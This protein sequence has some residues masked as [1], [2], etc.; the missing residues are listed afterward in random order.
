MPV[1]RVVATT[2]VVNNYAELLAITSDEEKKQTKLIFDQGRIARRYC[3]IELFIDLLLHHFNSSKRSNRTLVASYHLPNYKAP[4]VLSLWEPVL[5]T[6]L[7]KLNRKINT[8]VIYHKVRKSKRINSGQSL[9]IFIDGTKLT[10][11][12]NIRSVRHQLEVC[13][14]F[15]DR[16]RKR[17]WALLKEDDITELL[18]K[19][20][21]DQSE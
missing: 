9:I 4:L 10:V 14:N 8:Y 21:K 5:L 18:E 1:V 2:A 16:L 20:N 15:K 13:E 19:A 11:D 12:A 3:D 7:E 6:P 17:Q